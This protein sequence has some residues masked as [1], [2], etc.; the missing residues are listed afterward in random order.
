MK[1]FNTLSLSG[2]FLAAPMLL[3]SACGSDLT[4]GSQLVGQRCYA[5]QDCATSLVCSAAR[6]CIPAAVAPPLSP[7]MMAPDQDTRPDMPP[8]PDMPPVPDMDPDFDTGFPPDFGPECDADLGFGSYCIDR[9]TAGVCTTDGSFELP[10]SEGEVCEFGSCVPDEGSECVVGGRDDVCIG[11]QSRQV[12]VFDE[13]GNASYEVEFCEN[14]QFCIEGFCLFSEPECLPGGEQDFCLSERSRQFCTVENGA[15][16]Y[17]VERCGRDEFCVEGACVREDSECFPGDDFCLNDR[18][19]RVCVPDG[20]IFRYDTLRCDPNEFCSSGNCVEEEPEC[21]VGEQYCVTETVYEICLPGDQGG[22]T[23]VP[24]DCPP[25]SICENGSCV[26]ACVDNDGD[27]T[28]ANCEPFDCND[29]SF[30]VSPFQPE[31]CGDN[32]DNNCDF[33]TDE[34][35]GMGGCCTGANACAGGANTFCQD[36]TCVPY[37]PLFCQADGQPCDNI[38]S[39]DNNFYCLDLTGSGNGTCVGLCDY[40]FPDPS[41]TCNDPANQACVFGDPNGGAGICFDECNTSADCQAGD[42]KGCFF[43]DIENS[44]SAGVCVPKDISAP[45]PVGSPCDPNSFFSCDGSA[46]CVDLNQGMGGTCVQSCRPFEF[47]GNGTDCPAGNFCSAFGDAFGVCVPD[48]GASEF[49]VCLDQGTTCGEDA[50]SCYP[51]QSGGNRCR[52]TCRISQGDVDC[53]PMQD[54]RDVNQGQSEV[55][56][57]AARQP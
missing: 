3:L 2:L 25:N 43:Y 48:N 9:F 27:G 41:S 29:N 20:D 49:D 35:C 55:G 39:F 37:D 15:A 19:A 8:N 33:S 12:C 56:V 21:F 30:F 57:C 17:D 51:A 7:D 36:C 47:N 18:T 52:R 38:D 13:T 11:D 22:S 4:P 31:V 53:G 46:V 42:E 54:C 14:N 40:G 16:F 23:F 1:L 10:C 5:N 32:I 44:M 28:F 34:G 50:V 6:V 45:G 26:E 24:F